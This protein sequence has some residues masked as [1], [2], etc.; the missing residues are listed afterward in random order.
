MWLFKC[1]NWNVNDVSMLNC[2]KS[3]GINTENLVFNNKEVSEQ[4]GQ[5][6][7]D[8]LN[9]TSFEEGKSGVRVTSARSDVQKS[10][11]ISSSQA[12][13]DIRHL[14]RFFTK[15]TFSFLRIISDSLLYTFFYSLYFFLSL[16]NQIHGDSCQGKFFLRLRPSLTALWWMRSYDQGETRRAPCGLSLLPSGWAP[17]HPKTRNFSQSHV[18]VRIWAVFIYNQMDFYLFSSTYNIFPIIQSLTV[19]IEMSPFNYS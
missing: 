3:R 15:K 8:S 18:P 16:S 2:S 1:L 10:R 14:L 4:C 5:K 12:V 6:Q 19:I 9:V 7:H 13:T 11:A 17:C